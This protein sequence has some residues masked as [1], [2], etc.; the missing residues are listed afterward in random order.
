MTKRKSGILMHISSLPSKYGI[1]T[2]GKA[3][4]DFVDFLEKAGQKCWQVLPMGPTDFGN[5]P[6][7][8]SSVFAGN[9][10]FID[11]DVLCEEGL[12]SESDCQLNWG[13]DAEKVDFDLLLKQRLPLLKKAFSNFKPDEKLEKFCE[14]N[15]FWLE[16]YALYMALKNRFGCEWQK[17]PKALKEREETML[18]QAKKDFAGEVDFHI[19]LQ[20]KFD[21]QW[22]KLKAYAN[23]KEIEIIGDV[24]IYTAPDSSDTWAQP[25]QFQLDEEG[26]PSSVAGVPPD[27]FS[28]TGQLWGNP[29]YDWKAM[30]KDDYLWWSK[31]MEH[32][33]KLYDVVRID[34]FR[35]LE[36]YYSIPR[37]DK[38]AENGHWEKGPDIKLFQTLEKKLGKLNV[39]AED[40]GMLTEEVHVLRKATGFPGMKI[41]Q[42][43]FDP[44]VESSY[45]PHN[46]YGNTV[47]Y[48]GTHDNNTTL[49][50]FDSI[51]E[52]DKEFVCDYLNCKG[53]ED[54]S[55]AMIR[56]AWGTAAPLAMIQMQDVLDLPESCRMNQPGTLGNWTWRMKEDAISE[57]LAK[58]LNK[59]TKTFYR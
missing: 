14:E 12:L 50:W 7:Q 18:A 21:E 57:E 42:F 41:L 56:A 29:L 6:Y 20:Y 10:F 58:K 19:F 24:P 48:S 31:R 30:E 39:I 25:K 36:S 8:S 53:R 13:E 46:C 22:R 17:W 4:Y 5:S 27:A 34:H 33:L 40:L 15:S 3:A 1:G 23:K 49:G 28:E 51:S 11:L 2:F 45:M 37:G 59:L 52:S 9:P 43:S 44:T 55:W 16:D 32:D 38:T 47:V 54:I 26:Y 35:G